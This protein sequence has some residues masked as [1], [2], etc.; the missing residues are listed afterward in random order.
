MSPTKYISLEEKKVY[1]WKTTP[2][3]W[4]DALRSGDYEQTTGRLRCDD[5]FCCLGVLMDLEFPGQ[6]GYD[7]QAESQIHGEHSSLGRFKPPDWMLDAGDS[8]LG[9]WIGQQ[10]LVY[11]NDEMGQTFLN[12]ADR[13]EASL[14]RQGWDLS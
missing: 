9:N 12:I 4:I 3:Q 11:W 6:W 5:G 14:T 7:S 13:V 10:Q 8:E 1:V 2:R